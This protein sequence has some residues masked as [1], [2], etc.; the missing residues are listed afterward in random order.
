MSLI[1]SIAKVIKCKYSYNNKATKIE[2]KNSII[3]LL[4]HNN[5]P[6]YELMETLISAIQKLV[7]RDVVEYAD[8]RIEATRQVIQL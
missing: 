1:A 5:Q 2:L 8:R 3:H 7:I 4:T 6:H